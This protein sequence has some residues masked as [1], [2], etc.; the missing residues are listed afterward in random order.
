M[1]SAYQEL[2]TPV[3]LIDREI[4]MENIIRMQQ[5]ADKAG[6]EL[7]PHTKTHKMPYIA[8]LQLQAGACGIAVAKV[9]EAEAMA[10]AGITD[11]FIANEI[12]GT[13]KLER[14]R[15]LNESITVS[16]G[17]D[18]VEAL[19]QIETVFTPQ[20]PAN[21]LIEIEV[22]EQRSGICNEE[23]FLVLLNRL[24]TAKSTCLKGLFSHDG[25]TYHAKDRS[26]CHEWFVKAQEDTLHYADIARQQGFTVPV[27][28]FGSTPPFILG[29]T[30]L[31]GITELRIGTYALMDV[32]QSNV[33]GTYDTC[34]ASVLTAVISK[35]TA[36]RV[37]TD[38]GAK[39]LTMQEREKGICKTI[40]KGYVKH[41]DSIYLHSVYDEHG[42]F[43]SKPLH[44]TVQIGDKIEL[45]P[46]HICP[47]CNLYDTAY[48][49]SKGQVV[50]QIEVTARGKLT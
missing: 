42:I 17:L 25:H 27:I 38:S 3:L 49:V 11:I 44:D 47:V 12:V 9:G 26:Q 46:N 37:I 30:P 19:E 2:D 20:N 45:I 7:R 13:P 36:E 22:G 4:L 5:L 29:F 41:S 24:K 39:A 28:S 21:V 1:L 34:A 18:S 33:I 23:Q 10:Q 15:K 50:C 40:G 6:V 14:I 43:Y 32:S 16:F 31:P 35:P 48:L 8:K